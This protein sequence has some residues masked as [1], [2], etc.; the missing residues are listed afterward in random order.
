M[1]KKLLSIL[2]LFCLTVSS[3]WAQGPWTSGDCT[4][5]L[6][7]GVMTISGSGA[8]A[9]CANATSQPWKDYRSSITSVEVE[10]GVTYIGNL[11]FYNCKNMTSVVFPSSLTGI[12]NYAFMYCS[13]LTSV[14]IPDNVK[15]IG[16][17]SLSYCTGLTSLTIGNGVTTID[18]LAFEFCS[19]LS[20]V[21]IPSSVKSIG[22]R[23]FYHCGK[24]GTITFNSNPYIDTEVFNEIAAS[25]T[26]TMNLTANAAGGANWMTF[27]NKNYSFEADENTQVFKA[28]LSGTTI[29][30]NEV[31]DKIVDKG[32]AVVLKSTG[33]PVMTLTT[34]ASTNADANSLDG[35]SDAE[36]TT[37]D[38]TMFVLNY[39]E[40]TGVGFYRLQSGK[41]LG[42]GK[43]YLTYDG[44]LAPNFLGFGETTSINEEL[45]MKNEEFATAPVYDLQGR[46][47]A[48]P[49][50]GLYIVNGKKVIIK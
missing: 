43:A 37:S 36:G 12:G 17:S 45:R 23:A 32:T 44:A 4:L 3:V 14:T 8:M 40:G 15:T 25:A 9:D 48:Q 42:V 13:G 38:G 18:N 22:H 39:K 31:T 33:N 46:R 49:A 20:S 16:N 11:A 6:S 28:E 29:T 7:D 24:L 5:T 21:V 27:Y 30:L 47:V 2:A 19:K 35:V 1:R 34:S 41:T 26:I 10:E 50:K